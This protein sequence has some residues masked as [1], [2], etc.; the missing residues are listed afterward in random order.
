MKEN[1]KKKNPH[2]K[3]FSIFLI[4]ESISATPFSECNFSPHEVTQAIVLVPPYLALCG[5]L[6]LA[7]RQLAHLLLQMVSLKGQSNETKRYQTC[8]ILV[9]ELGGNVEKYIV[10][11]Y[12]FTSRFKPVYN[13]ISQEEW[14]K[15][16]EYI[17]DLLEWWN[18]QHWVEQFLGELILNG[19]ELQNVSQ[20]VDNLILEYNNRRRKQYGIEEWNEILNELRHFLEDFFHE[21][22]TG[23]KK[24]HEPLI[25]FNPF[26][27]FP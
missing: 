9:E 26:R 14:K 5:C 20:E 10:K 3:S 1:G 27:E 19:K 2:S 22:Y 12:D 18:E 17:K 13:M 21:Y 4:I 7:C 11:I 25:I 6:E 24:N 16:W 15:L 8:Q 23:T